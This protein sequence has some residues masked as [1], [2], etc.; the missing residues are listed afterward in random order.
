MISKQKYMFFILILFMIGTLIFSKVDAITNELPLLGRVIFV[1]P[2]HGGRDPGTTYGK[3]MEKD[4]VLEISQVLRDELMK[5]G[6]IVYMTRET[7]EDL[8]SQWDVR[9]KRGDLYRRI[10]MYKKYQAELYLSIH[11]NY[12]SN[13]SESGAEVLYNPINSENKIFGEILMNNFKTS[14]GSK[15]KLKRTDLYMYQNTTVP[16]VLIECGFLSNPNE[17]YLMQKKDYQ[18]K[19]S[20]II[21]DSVITY[22]NH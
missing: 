12:Y 22:F 4:I 18:Q 5:K 16:G 19:L 14:L 20:R 2:G 11:I 15:R 21:T 10:L 17:R 13:S 6:A 8:S 7:D 9:K 3:I 1:D